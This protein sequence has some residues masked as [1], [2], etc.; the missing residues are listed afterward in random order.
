[1]P[2]EIEAESHQTLFFGQQGASQSFTA[3]GSYGDDALE[4][5]TL[6]TANGQRFF[7]RTG[8]PAEPVFASAL[9]RGDGTYG[10]GAS[11]IAGYSGNEVASARIDF[12]FAN[13]INQAISF[14]QQV[15]I[16][17]LEALAW[18][19]TSGSGEEFGPIVVS[20]S[21]SE[22]FVRVRADGTREA[23][24]RVF[25]Y[26]LELR[27]N[28][29]TGQFER[30]FSDDLLFELQVMGSNDFI[31]GREFVDTTVNG[32]SIFGARIDGF[33]Q[34]FDLIELDVD[35][36]IELSFE[37]RVLVART[38]ETGGPAF[39]GDP[40]S[41]TIDTPAFVFDTS[42]VAS[43]VPEPGRYAMLAAGL[44]LLVLAR[45]RHRPKASLWGREDLAFD[46]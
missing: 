3:S 26:S 13:P 23:P 19:L 17:P 9:A 15:R 6:I 28:E 39:A 18:V 25:D 40:F 36:Q 1:M 42:P 37:A 31:L 27:K 44:A 10:V 4:V 24:E 12:S 46:H 32:N 21:V 43:P 7:S 30:R 14:T 22:T 38:A 5:E 2:I 45:C 29:Q 11:G 34:T 41:V 20:A 16:E 35:E 33:E 8:G